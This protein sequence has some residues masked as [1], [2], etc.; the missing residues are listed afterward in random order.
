[1]K[2]LLLAGTAEGRAIAKGL[3][4]MPGVS[5]MASLAGAVRAPAPL[6]IPTRIGGFGTAEGFAQVLHAERIG[7]VVDA[8]HP[9]AHRISAR[10]AQ[11]CAEQGIAYLQVLRPEW[12]AGPG[13]A[14]TMIRR[15]EDA[16]Q[17]IAPGSCVF[18][19]TGRQTL[20]GFEN[21][22]GRR[23]I[24]RQIDPPDDA[25]P[26]P[27][28]EYLVGRPPFS[29]EDEIA[30]FS[31]LNVDWLVVKNAGGAASRSKLDAARAL[32]MPVAMI[33]RPSPPDAESV[34]TVEA[35][36]ARIKEHAWTNASS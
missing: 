11:V 9:F 27:G 31:R 21:L 10:S 19:A 25:F 13:D 12:V 33:T 24:C 36:L 28:G 14:W 32:G 7:L 8:T 6:P 30:L 18:L 34:T 17:H 16:A 15:E 35:A 29:V 23:L 3:S 20:G 22:T 2:V 5:G 4:E 26:F 1:M